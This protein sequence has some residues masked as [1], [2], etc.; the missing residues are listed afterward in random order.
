MSEA[1]RDSRMVAIGMCAAVAEARE[2]DANML[3]RMYLEQAM[4]DGHTPCDAL[5]LLV[6]S[7]IG[8]A[9]GTQAGADW[10]RQV[11]VGMARFSPL[12]D[13]EEDEG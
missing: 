5:V 12:P 13:P 6:K 11:A 10:F 7:S 9:V 2:D 3:L 1:S 8:V 4:A